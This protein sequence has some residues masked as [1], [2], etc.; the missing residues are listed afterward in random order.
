M[1][2]F[3]NGSGLSIARSTNNAD[4]GPLDGE[5]SLK[6]DDAVGDSVINL[7]W[8]AHALATCP[9]LECG[10]PLVKAEDLGNARWV[11]LKLLGAYPP[12]T[13]I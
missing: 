13:T 4:P 10:M 1:Q 3:E 12:M 2:R 8:V 7:K 6:V 9:V 11:G 5:L